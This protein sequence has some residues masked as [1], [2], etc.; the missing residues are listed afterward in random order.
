MLLLT[1]GSM[2]NS[3]STF[4]GERSSDQEYNSSALTRLVPE[5]ELPVYPD[6]D[7]NE[8][9]EVDIALQEL[10]HLNQSSLNG[11]QELLKLATD[12]AFRNFLEVMIRQRSAQCAELSATLTKF[13]PA[14][15]NAHQ[16]DAG[17][18]DPNSSDLRVLWIRAVWNYEQEQFGPFAEK[19]ELAE[20]RLEDAYLAAA[21]AVQHSDVAGLFLSHAMD[22]CGARQR[23]E[24]LTYN[25]A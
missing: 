9:Y 11:Y 21:E 18:I 1:F 3:F 24:D 2:F 14:A 20:S 22:V 25:L 6:P 10:L 7:E 17:L 15:S 4:N 13:D 12:P 16:E 19:M 23:I 8:D 5:E